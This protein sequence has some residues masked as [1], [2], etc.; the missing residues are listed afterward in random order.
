MKLYN[1]E[2]NKRDTYKNEYDHALI[3]A[4]R[5]NNEIMTY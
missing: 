2:N 5:I 3:K 4:E 1:E